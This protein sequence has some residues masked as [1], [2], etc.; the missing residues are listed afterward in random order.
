MDSSGWIGLAILIVL[1]GSTIYLSL[2]RRLP[3]PQRPEERLT[4]TALADVERNR[5]QSFWPGSG[6]GPSPN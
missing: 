1:I 6:G 5:A 2:R 3:T 4:I